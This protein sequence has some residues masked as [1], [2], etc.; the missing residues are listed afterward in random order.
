MLD[1]DNDLLPAEKLST[2]NWAR[3]FANA[4]TRRRSAV[5][6]WVKSRSIIAM[7]DGTCG[8]CLC[9]A[10]CGRFG[11]SLRKKSYGRNGITA[12][13]PPLRLRVRRFID[14]WRSAA[15]TGTVLMRYEDFVKTP[16]STLQQVC[17]QLGLPWDPAMLVWPKAAERIADR[18]NGNGS[19]WN[20]R[21]A[22][23]VGYSWLNIA[24]TSPAL[25]HA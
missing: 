16:E 23:S 18:K 8:R 2:R 19:F 12:E 6:G 20:S 24:R 22:N 17:Y 9:S 25:K 3:P 14:D 21:S 1:A 11:H 10:T 13:D 7:Q 5:F 15:A 4:S